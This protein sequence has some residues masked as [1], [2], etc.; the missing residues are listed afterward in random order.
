MSIEWLVNYQT[1]CQCLV[2]ILVVSWSNRREYGRS[3]LR[4]HC[5]YL[6]I[7]PSWLRQPSDTRHQCITLF[8]HNKIIIKNPNNAHNPRFSISHA[9]QSRS[10][11]YING[12]V[13][14]FF[15][16]MWTRRLLQNRPHHLVTQ[17]GRFGESRRKV[18]LDP[19][20][21]VPVGLEVAKWDAVGPGL[22]VVS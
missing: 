10:Y 9:M 20:E 6:A 8:M 13:I 11:W 21:S 2:C 19:L 7:L 5:M 18:F 3:L 17:L 1:Q 15:L 14:V 12:I 22:I 16:W 4:L